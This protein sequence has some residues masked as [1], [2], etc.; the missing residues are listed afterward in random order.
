MLVEMLGGEALVAGP[1]EAL[2]LRL[3]VQR[4]PFGGRMAQTAVQKTRLAI[5][6]EAAA[7]AT[8]GPL[9]HTQHLSRRDLIELIRFISA[10]YTP[11][12]D[13]PHTLQGFRPAHP[14]P[15]KA[16]DLP[17]RSCAT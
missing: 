9:A 13:H 3:V 11:E 2:D 12:P 17:D 14:N 10:Q 5:V 4:H 8:E 6:L 16:T 15:R 1:V 7:P